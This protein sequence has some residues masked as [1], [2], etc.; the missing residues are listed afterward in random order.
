MKAS[1]FFNAHHA[2]MGAFATFTLGEAGAKG[3]LG[4]ELGKPADQNVF[5]GLETLQPGRFEA[6]PFTAQTADERARY[7][8]EATPTAA[9]APGAQVVPF[10]RDAIRREFRLGS[11][12]WKAGDLTF[13]ILSPVR[14]IPDPATAAVEELKRALLPAVLVELTVD[15]SRGPV[16]RRAFFGYQGT[17]PYSRMRRIDETTDGQLTGVGQGRLTAIVTAPQEGVVSGQGFGIGDILMPKRP[18]NLTFA[19]GGVAA[20]VLTVPAGQTR[21]FRLAVCFHRGGVVTTGLDTTYFYTRYF[22][23]IEDVGAYALDQFDTLKAWAAEA[24]A[25]VETSR[26]S[27][28][29]K[30]MLV[31]SIRSYYGSTQLLDRDGEPVWVVNEGEYRMMNTFDLTVDHL[32]FELRMNPWVVRNVLDLFVERYSYRDEVRFP[33]DAHPHPGGL[34]FTHDM[35]Q[36]NGFSRPGYSTYEMHGLDGCFSHM[37]HEQLVNWVLC[38]C[39]YAAQTGDRDWTHRRLSVFEDCLA[40]LVN[41]D[42]PDTDK[43]DGIMDL[44]STRTM[45]GAEITTYDSLDASLGQSRSNLYMAV[46]CWAAYVLLEKFFR[47]HGLNA[48]SAEAG[49]QAE[50]CAAT[51]AAKVT[52]EGYLPAVFEAGNDSRIIPAIE[53]LV[54]PQVAGCREALDPTGRFGGLIDVLRRHIQAVLKPGVCLF[55]EGGW[56]ISST[57]DNSWLSKI[58]LCQH[59]YRTVLGF[60]WDSTGH[61]ADAAHAAWL[62]DPRNTYWCWSDQI[63]SGLAKGSKYYPRGVTAILWLS[64]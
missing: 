13:R 31:H 15:N 58:Y 22:P 10:A 48:W 56:K 57:S 61:A 21:T 49:R 36:G 37:T 19:L 52:A 50:R 30:F 42:H 46:K 54:F 62:L 32:F 1:F 12:T 27:E 4:L 34:S 43:R 45:G 53:G 11:D 51:L 26:L 39:T 7:D 29:Q 40:S 35:G 20:L 63:V 18:E 44:D 9:A 47:Q 14:G 55:P 38:G 33:G 59:V 24:D 16:P 5:I 3:G 2:P 28:E 41:R 23:S 8:V 17:D 25:R 60:A 6:L 64:E